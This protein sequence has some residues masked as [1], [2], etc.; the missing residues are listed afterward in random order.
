MALVRTVA[1]SRVAVLKV[2]VWILTWTKAATVKR[3]VVMVMARGSAR[4][5]TFSRVVL[6]R[7]RGGVALVMRL[8]RRNSESQECCKNPH[9]QDAEGCVRRAH[10]FR[11]KHADRARARE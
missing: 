7:V 5:A 2:F 10:G 1:Q 4:V 3:A 9:R 11:R 8:N 6:M